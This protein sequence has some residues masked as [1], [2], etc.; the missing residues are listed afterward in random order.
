MEQETNDNSE[1]EF[2]DE[3]NTVYSSYFMYNILT[4]NNNN[5]D[6]PEFVEMWEKFGNIEVAQLI[7]SYLHPEEFENDIIPNMKNY[8]VLF[9]DAYRDAKIGDTINSGK[10]I[11]VFTLT[12]W[13]YLEEITHEH[14][15]PS[16]KCCS[17]NSC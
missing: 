4:N 7:D 15:C 3:Q 12:V 8:M 9:K 6:D 16:E 1:Y 13:I 5:I 11:G 10:A 14:C 2:T 17:E